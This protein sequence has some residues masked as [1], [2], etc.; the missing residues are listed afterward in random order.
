[1]IQ[2]LINHPKGLSIDYDY[3]YA[4]RQRPTQRT[5]KEFILNRVE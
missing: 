5:V 2:Y 3:H 1:M 4:L